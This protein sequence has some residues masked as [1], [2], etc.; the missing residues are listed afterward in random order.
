MKRMIIM[1]LVVILSLTANAS[2]VFAAPNFPTRRVEIIVPFGPGSGTDTTARAI[3]APLEKVLGVPVI[4]QNV[5]GSSGLRG[6]EHASRQ[7]ADGY[8]IFLNNTT[9]I[10]LQAQNISP[11]ALTESFDPLVCLVQD[12]VLFTAAANGRFKTWKEVVAHAKENPGDV[13][14]SG[15]SPRGIDGL[16]TLMTAK[17]AGIEVTFVSFNSGA[18]A[19]T[20]ILGGHVDL[21]NMGPADAAEMIESGE[22]IGLLIT[23]E[24]RLST[25]PDV[26]TTVEEGINVTAGAWRGLAVPKGT[27][28]EVIAILE[29]AIREAYDSPEFQQWLV[30]FS[31]DERYA[32]KNSKEFG[33]FWRSELEQFRGAFA[34]LGL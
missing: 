5:E 31:L 14:V 16:S 12:S 32:W 33:E 11:I 1:V 6:L 20:A 9:H 2:L 25:V 10:L 7:P 27:P 18:E 4:V 21:G 34:E 28:P 23:S 29:S 30:D 15:S 3:A 17:G 24:N 22:M 19:M 13:T 26:P 8:T